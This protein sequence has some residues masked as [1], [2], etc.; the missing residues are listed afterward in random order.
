MTDTPTITTGTTVG[1]WRVAAV[2]GRV[3]ACQCCCG[4][5][6]T[7]AV[8]ALADGSASPSCGCTLLTAPQ[9]E[10][11]RQEA[12]QELRRRDLKDWKPQR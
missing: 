1:H 6:R 12:E 3:A 10:A 8:A 11:L 9:H 7:I 4:A 2:N 5:I